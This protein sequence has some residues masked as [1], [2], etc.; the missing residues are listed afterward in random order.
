MKKVISTLML[1]FALCGAMS[2]NAQGLEFSD[3]L[4]TYETIADSEGDVTVKGIKPGATI[5]EEIVMPTTVDL[6]GTKYTVAKMNG[7]VFSGNKIIKK[8]VLPE[9]LT[10]LE[11]AVFED[12]IN[13]ETV[14][15][16]QNLKWIGRYCFIRDT[17]LKNITIPESVEVIEADAFQDC[18]SIEEITIPDGVT[19]LGNN[20]FLR[21]GFKKVTFGAGLKQ[22]G[23]GMCWGCPNLEEVVVAPETEVINIDCFQWCGALKTV[24][25]ANVGIIAAHAFGGSENITT[26]ISTAETAPILGLDVFE[27]KVYDNATVFVKSEDAKAEYMADTNWGNFKKY[28]ILPETGIANIALDGAT[29]TVYNLQGIR[30]ADTIE[31]VNEAGLYIC[32]GK[33]VLIRR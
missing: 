8:V 4:F 15:L 10:T 29:A 11:Y 14:V 25:I 28:E 24:N 23:A 16:P 27:Q 30:V 3:N 21:T 7:W 1:G 17:A 6:N 33:K 9:L 13:L 2:V 19:T 20:A 12:C 18:S 22:L 32:G 31:A 26:V 5:P